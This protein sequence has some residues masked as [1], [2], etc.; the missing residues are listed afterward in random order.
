MDQYK[1]LLSNTLIFAI[2][3]FSSKILV[4]LLMP[5]YTSILAPAQYS[6]AGLVIDTANFIIP[7]TAVCIGEAVIRFGLEKTAR[8]S[9]VFSSAIL[10]VLIG[11]A[12]FLAFYPL[13]NLFPF[14]KGYTYLVYLYVLASS[15]KGIC[16]QFIRAKGYVRLYAFDGIFSTVMVI[17]FMI[18]GLVV[19][20]WGIVG[21]VLAT[22]LSDFISALF[23][24]WIAGLW[25]YFRIKRLDKSLWKIM[26]FYSLPLIPNAVFFWVTNL[27]DRY[28]V[29][30]I[31]GSDVNGLYTI[32]YKI[33]NLLTVISSIFMQAWQL[34]AF[35]ETDERVRTRFFSTVFD[36]YQSLLFVAGSGIILLIQPITRIL[37]DKEY[38]DS[39]RY[40]P[41]LIIAIVFSCF[42]TFFSSIYMTEKRNNMTMI[43]TFCGAAINVILNF[44]LIPIYKAN[45][46]AFATFFSYFIVFLFRAFHSRRYI[47]VNVR[48]VRLCANLIVLLAQAIIMIWQPSTWVFFEIG[49]T[50]VMIL[51]NAKTL[52]T[53]L[54][55]LFEQR[56][57]PA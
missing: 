23:L 50:A 54:L 33:P 21:Y 36:A 37:V 26:L 4:F 46:A 45:G 35:S 44:T 27:S 48:W 3:A 13:M 17:L 53:A 30:A 47:Q 38:F 49:L 19:F 10:T 42:A 8:K 5:I 11:F 39:W 34:S 28:I 6:T 55:K 25:R 56:R 24:I 22:I 51:I 31:L 2:G 41:F 18:L 32:A 7:I 29:T 12:V 15:F 1:K 43:T 40:V 57:R 14:T 20:K 52:F 16:A 9:D